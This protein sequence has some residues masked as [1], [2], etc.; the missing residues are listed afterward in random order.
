LKDEQALNMGSG[1][2]RAVGEVLLR[3]ILGMNSAGVSHQANVLAFCLLLI[4]IAPKGLNWNR[5]KNR[6]QH[7]LGRKEES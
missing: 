4:W 6:F 2:D 7:I 5:R 1:T 3:V